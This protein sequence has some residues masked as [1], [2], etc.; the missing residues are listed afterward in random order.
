MLNILVIL[1]FRFAPVSCMPSGNQGVPWVRCGYGYLPVLGAVCGPQ[2]RGGQSGTPCFNP[3]RWATVPWADTSQ[4]PSGGHS[5]H[6]D[7]APQEACSH[8]SAPHRN[9][10]TDNRPEYPPVKPLTE[11]ERAQVKA[12]GR[13]CELG[14]GEIVNVYEM[15]HPE[16]AHMAEG[17]GIKYQSSCDMSNRDLM[18][19]VQKPIEEKGKQCIFVP[20]DSDI[21]YSYSKGVLIE[22]DNLPT[23]DLPI[24]I[25]GT[26]RHLY[27]VKPIT[28][29][30]LCVADMKVH[31]FQSVTAN[32]RK[33]QHEIRA[34]GSRKGFLREEDVRNLLNREA[35]TEILPSPFSRLKIDRESI[36]KLTEE[37]AIQRLDLPE[38]INGYPISQYADLK[39]AL[40]DLGAVAAL[41]L[42]GKP[43]CEWP[44]RDSRLT[45]VTSL[46]PPIRN[47]YT[48]SIFLFRGI[49]PST[50]DGQVVAFEDPNQGF[51]NLQVLAKRRKIG[52]NRIKL[53]L[54]E[55]F[56][57]K[58]D[59]IFDN[60]KQK[61]NMIV[62]EIE[63]I[64][65][66]EFVDCYCSLFE[67]TDACQ[68]MFVFHELLIFAG[69]FNDLGRLRVPFF[70]KIKSL[71]WYDEFLRLKETYEG[72][73]LDL[74]SY[75]ALYTFG[76]KGLKPKI[77]VDL[78]AINPNQ[79]PGP[80][81]ILWLPVNKMVQKLNLSPSYSL[82]EESLLLIMGGTPEDYPASFTSLQSQ[83]CLI[84][85]GNYAEVLKKAKI[86]PELVITCVYKKK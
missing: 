48:G 18:K 64:C 40:S 80:E 77:E 56:V 79:D 60:G 45:L 70:E 12:L 71:F 82:F 2:D 74:K 3:S 66:E 4:A 19:S 69:A 22:C 78:Y 17:E 61:I 57:K 85:K 84:K 16:S 11:E 67:R 49:F 83:I 47:T 35:V 6:P 73:M 58:Y 46:P 39:S 15:L 13:I 54:S 42:D 43:V 28:V 21:E 24:E 27:S 9:P 72:T 62:K 63:D 86:D 29:K 8:H 31:T 30:Y 55:G 20:Y 5:R 37:G 23:D 32:L 25:M 59:H 52:I 33:V 81:V 14:L 51:A 34:T 76:T 75:Q 36:E 53:R 50:L 10:K 68:R 26:D 44:P 1:V 65:N 38:N 41:Y 7:Q